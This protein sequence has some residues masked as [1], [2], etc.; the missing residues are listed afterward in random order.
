MRVRERAQT[1]IKRGGCHDMN[2]GT[3]ESKGALL[4]FLALY[5]PA[6]EGAPS[7]W[8]R[9]GDDN[10]KAWEEFVK[11]AEARGYYAYPTEETSLEAEDAIKKLAEYGN[12]AEK[13]IAEGL[14]KIHDKMVQYY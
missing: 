12:E 6:P 13:V 7:D 8:R 1:I 14:A 11:T 2:D 10:L 3:E 4:L 9:H 5:A